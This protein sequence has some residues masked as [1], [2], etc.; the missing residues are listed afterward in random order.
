MFLLRHAISPLPRRVLALLL[1]LMALSGVLVAAPQSRALE[2]SSTIR[3]EGD[4]TP[5]ALFE[6]LGALKTAQAFGVLERSIGQVKS[7]SK[8]RAIFTAMR[9]FLPDEELGEK[10]IRLTLRYAK[11]RDKVEAPPAAT[12]LAGFGAAALLAGAALRVRRWVGMRGVRGVGRRY[13]DRHD[14]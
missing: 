1:A 12:A 10:A 4:K 14:R 3:R 13:R 7:A 5:V 9:H 8:Y 11:G 2:I 6:E